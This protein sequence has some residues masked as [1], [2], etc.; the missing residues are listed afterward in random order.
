M[1]WLRA[2]GQ[3]RAGAILLVVEVVVE[4]EVQPLD[5]LVWGDDLPR[6]LS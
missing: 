5:I 1:G 4:F 6:G 2:A 3:A